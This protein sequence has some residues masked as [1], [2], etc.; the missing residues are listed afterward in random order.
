MIKKCL[1]T[2]FD[3]IHEI[4]NDAAVAYK[5]I[6]PHD[7][8]HEPYMTVNALKKQIDE[9]V[10]FWGYY[11][12]NTLVGVMGLQIKKDVNL[13]RH[14]YIK[15]KMRRQGIG[16]KLLSYLIEQSTLP[17]LIGTWAAAKWAIDFYK[18]NGFTQVDN[19]TKDLLLK[20]YWSIPPRQV[21]TSV[22]FNTTELTLGGVFGT[23]VIATVTLTSNLL[24][25]K[26]GK[27][28][29]KVVA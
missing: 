1:D 5:G 27:L 9:Q 6:I 29:F 26:S 19:D 8:W 17:M 21:E 10:I 7:R 11:H 20:K 18:K 15:T 16:G 24:V 13:I 3:E 22:V 12:E 28:I 2:E 14:A 4:I 25:L 23:S